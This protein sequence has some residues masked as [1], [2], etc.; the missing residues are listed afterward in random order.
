M[1]L[2]AV[3]VAAP[4]FFKTAIVLK[5]FFVLLPAKD[6]VALFPI[7]GRVVL[8]QSTVWTLQMGYWTSVSPW[9]CWQFDQAVRRTLWSQELGLQLRKVGFGTSDMLLIVGSAYAI[10]RDCGYKSP[11]GQRVS[12]VGH[13]AN[14][15]VVHALVL[16]AMD[17][18]SVKEEV[19]ETG[20]LAFIEG[21]SDLQKRELL[22]FQVEW[23]NRLG[24]YCWFGED[25]SLG[26]RMD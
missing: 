25:E 6:V 5:F 13:L 19:I 4:G 12:V 20:R 17:L 11:M 23:A 2:E 14:M 15:S 7:F 18:S 10:L 9:A 26:L 8:E 1:Q 3:A 24:S 22:T 21:R 16:C